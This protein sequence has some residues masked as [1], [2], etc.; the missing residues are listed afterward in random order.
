[1]VNRSA[2]LAEWTRCTRIIGLL[3]LLILA[4]LLQACGATKV[5][6]N[7]APDFAYWYLD[8]Q[9]AFTDAQSL[10][11]KDALAKLQ[12]WHRQN[13][14]P[15]AMAVLQKLQQQMP[16]DMDARA[17]CAPL[18]ELQR[19]WVALADQAQPAIAAVA[20]TLGAEQLVQLE[21]RFALGNAYFQ[22]DFLEARPRD[23]QDRRL[24]QAISRAE[25][26]YGP[27][28]HKQLSVIRRHIEQSHFD[29][30]LIYAERL[31]RQQDLL[32]TLRPLIAGQA[33]PQAT[34]AALHGLLDRTRHSPDPAYRRYSDKM[35]RQTCAVLADLHN[36]T[37]AAQR[38]HA[39]QTLNGQVQD[40]SDLSAHTP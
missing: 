34:Q 22:S 40:L 28:D 29:A 3:G 39:V 9:L 14:L 16:S 17:A 19:Q 6:Y 30:R 20:G 24:Q 7:Q 37:T 15:G 5:L 26:L 27:L 4:G 38:R 1:M 33:S 36:S 35:A 10:Q 18:V 2:V 25:V 8:G 12:A 11:V 23:V 21:Q 32:Q 31:R 13:Q